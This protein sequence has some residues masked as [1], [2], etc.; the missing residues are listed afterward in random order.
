MDW[1]IEWLDRKTAE[2]EEGLAHLGKDDESV[3]GNY[4]G[5]LQAL[6]DTKALVHLHAA[7]SSNP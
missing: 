2:T 3:Q 5:Y 6:K 7:A 1:L 4:L